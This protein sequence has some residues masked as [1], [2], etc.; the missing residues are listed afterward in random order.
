MSVATIHSAALVGV[1]AHLVD[2]EVAII[3]SLPGMRTVGLPDAALREGRDRVLLAIRS[4]KL[5]GARPSVV[6]N[7]AP[8]ELHKSGAGFELAIALGILVCSGIVSREAVADLLVVGEL[9]LHGLVRP[10]RGVLAV[11]VLAERTEG[12]RRLIVPRDNARE[13][14][15]VE[16]IPIVPVEHLRELAEGLR[17]DGP[18]AVYDSGQEVVAEEESGPLLLDLG[19]VRGQLQ[20]KR[21]A[22]VAAAG[23]H[24]LLFVGPPGS[25]KTMIARR[26]PGILPPL[27][28]EEALSTTTVASAAGLL[29]SGAG[30][31]RERPFR[32]PHHT[33]SSAGL[34]GGYAPPR[35]GEVSLAHNGVLFLDELAEFSRRAL[36]SL[37]E[38]LEEGVVHIVRGGTRVDF[39]SRTVLV[40]AT[41]P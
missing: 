10:V 17:G 8:A 38:P 19:D 26:L 13:A 23:S 6:V 18:L 40:A 35:P 7:L 29:R 1:D 24:N 28:R 11:A 22:E 25:G 2:V 41:N 31:L 14:A 27:S 33:I 34:V 20:A 4:Q 5:I 39:P 12:V 15:L 16:G 21:A 30:L 36:E 9:S 32:A 3:N 37:R